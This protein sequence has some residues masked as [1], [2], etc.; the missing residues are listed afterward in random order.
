MNQA[1]AQK[2]PLVKAEILQNPAIE[3]EKQKK[4][5]GKA[6]RHNPLEAKKEEVNYLPYNKSMQYQILENDI[7]NDLEKLQTDYEKLIEKLERKRDP[8]PGRR[9]RCCKH[10]KFYQY[11]LYEPEVSEDVKYCSTKSPVVRSIIQRDYDSEL[12]KTLKKRLQTIQK[13]REKLSSDSLPD[14]FESKSPGLKRFISPVFIDTKRFCNIWEDT[15]FVTKGLNANISY[16]ETDRG[17]MVRSKSE[18]LIANTLNRLCIPYKYECPIEIGSITIHPDFTIINPDTGRIYYWEHL[19][20]ADDRQYMNDAIKR[21]QLYEECGIA[22]GH[23]LILTFET[24]S[25]PLNTRRIE[26][27][28]KL[29]VK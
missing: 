1:I 26:T 27:A 20:M 25:N 16:Q 9:I 15:E 11:Y 28:I 18:L 19:G 5:A 10:K 23:N 3:S 24:Q 22:L 4:Q 17:E 29:Y 2:N 7:V 13:C 6:E 21:L 8:F 12:A 14:I